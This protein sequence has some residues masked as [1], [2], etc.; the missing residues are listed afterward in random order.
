MFI[1]LLK[2]INYYYYAQSV[3]YKHLPILMGHYSWYTSRIF[4]FESGGKGTPV[5]TIKSEKKII[6]N[7]YFCIF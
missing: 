6:L 4:Y 5:M 7:N 3:V 2:D 1:A